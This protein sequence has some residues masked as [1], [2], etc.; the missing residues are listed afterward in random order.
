MK[1]HNEKVIKFI[2]IDENENEILLTF[3][4]GSKLLCYHYQECCESV[5]L[6]SVEGDFK[7]LEG[8]ALRVMRH[9]CEFG[10]TDYGIRG[11]TQIVFKT[12]N[13]T[14]ITKWIGESNGYYSVEVSIK[15]WMEE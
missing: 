2:D 8:M 1:K 7:K 10:E 5:S 4:D 15:E 12:D 11:E 3:E 6:I 13:E 9:T 14:V